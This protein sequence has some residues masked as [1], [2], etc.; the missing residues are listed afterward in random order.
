[1]PAEL[2]YL[3][4][5]I[6]ELRQERAAFL[7]T[8]EMPLQ[9][10]RVPSVTNQSPQ[11][12]KI[13]LFRRLFRGREDVYPKRFESMKTGKKGYQPVCGNEWVD[14]ICEKPKIRCEDCRQRKFL[15]VTD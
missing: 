10:D 14:G 8:Q 3:L 4:T 13:A 5:R 15:P 12:P 9:P 7:P 6:I 11:E 1:M 2:T